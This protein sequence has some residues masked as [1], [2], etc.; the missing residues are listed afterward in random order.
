ML[1]RGVP[2]RSLVLLQVLLSTRK[3][4]RKQALLTQV[5]VMRKRLSEQALRHLHLKV[6][7]AFCV[8]C[9][10]FM[11]G[12]PSRMAAAA[13]DCVLEGP[14][15]SICRSRVTDL[16]NTIC[17]PPCPHICIRGLTPHGC[18]YT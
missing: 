12:S 8:I 15:M 3:L 14:W 4:L 9:A 10:K 1:P 7:A 11:A 18:I 2:W 13:A 5:L 16:H 17:F 6:R